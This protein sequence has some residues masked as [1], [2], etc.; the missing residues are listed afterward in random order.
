M[1]RP[2]STYAFAPRSW[3]GWFVTVAVGLALLITAA[4]FLTVA[5]IVGAVVAA[6][7]VARAYW[8]I[9]KAERKRSEEFLRA[10]YRVEYE[11]GAAG[12][13]SSNPRVKSDERP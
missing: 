7:L 13:H 8:L 12:E 4:L 11:D 1:N 5:L 2:A 6:F 9:R 10:E 3:L